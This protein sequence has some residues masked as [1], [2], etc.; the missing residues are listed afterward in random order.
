MADPRSPKS[1]RKG[2]VVNLRVSFLKDTIHVFQIPVKAV[3]QVLWDAVVSHMQL[4]ESDY[5]GLEYSNHNDDDCWLDNNKQILKQLPSPDTLLRFG[6]KF[7]TPDPGLLE[8]ELTRYCFALQ[9]RRDLQCGHLHCSENTAALLASYIVQ[10]EIGD[11]LVDEYLDTSYLNGFEFV[12][13]GQQTPEML[14]KVMDYHRQHVGEAPSE[15]DSN[16][17]DTARKVEMYGIKFHPAK[18]HE[19]VALH[20]AVAHLGVLVFQ[21]MTRINTF[22]WAKVRKLSF[23]RKKFLIKLHPE[24]YGYYKDTVEFFFD[25][26]DRCKYFWKKCIEH[27][28]FFRCQ[29][30]KKPLR[31][32][33]RVVSRGSSFRYSGRTQKELQEFVRETVVKRPQVERSTSG[34]ISSRST[35]VTPKISA[36]PSI[37]NSSDLHNSTASSGSHILESLGS[38]RLEHG[39]SADSDGGDLINQPV[40]VAAVDARLPHSDSPGADSDF[41]KFDDIPLSVSDHIILPPDVPYSNLIQSHLHHHDLDENVTDADVD[42]EF[43]ND[44]RLPSPPELLSA[45]QNGEGDSETQLKFVGEVVTPLDDGVEMTHDGVG[46]VNSQSLAEDR[47]TDGGVSTPYGHAKDAGV[48]SRAEEDGRREEAGKV[49]VSQDSQVSQRLDS[50]Q[51]PA[52]TA[53]AGAAAVEDRPDPPPPDKDSLPLQVSVSQTP[54]VIQAGE[55]QSGEPQVEVTR[56]DAG[57]VTSASSVSTGSLSSAGP[58]LAEAD[59][60]EEIPYVLYRRQY[61]EGEDQQDPGLLR[62]AETPSPQ[63]TLFR[64]SRS[65]SPRG[66]LLHED[67][68]SPEGRSG[69]TRMDRSPSAG[70]RIELVHYNK[71]PARDSFSSVDDTTSPTFDKD[72]LG[73]AHVDSP[74]TESKPVIWV[75]DGKS[76]GK[77]DSKHASPKRQPVVPEIK[78]VSSEVSPPPPPRKEGVPENPPDSA[79]DV[80]VAKSQEKEVVKIDWLDSEARDKPPAVVIG[81]DTTPKKDVQEERERTDNT[82]PSV[83]RSV[84]MKGEGK[85]AETLASPPPPPPETEK[86]ASPPPPPPE[87]EKLASPPPPPPETEKLASPPPPPPDTEKLASPP[88]PP[89]ETEKLAS[90]PPPPPE[91]EKLAS[92]PPPPPE[93]EKLASPPPPPPETEK[94]ASPP[95]PP[96]ETEKLASP[97]PPPPVPPPPPLEM[98]PKEA[99]IP[100]EPSPPLPPPPSSPPL[101]PPPPP[102]RPQNPTAEMDPNLTP[103]VQQPVLTTISTNKVTVAKPQV[104]A[105]PKPPPVMPKTTKPMS[106]KPPVA[107]KTKTIPMKPPRESGGP[108]PGREGGVPNVPPP[109]QP[110]PLPPVPPSPGVVAHPP[111]PPQPPKPLPKAPSPPRVSPPKISPPTSTTAEEQEFPPPPSEMTSSMISVSSDLDLETL[112]PPPSELLIDYS[113]QSSGTSPESPA[114]L[115]PLPPEISMTQAPT[116]TTQTP[117]EEQKGHK[118]KR[119]SS[120]SLSGKPLDGGERNGEGKVNGDRSSKQPKT[121]GGGK[122]G[123]DSGRTSSEAQRMMDLPSPAAALMFS[124]RDSPPATKPEPPAPALTFTTFRPDPSEADSIVTVTASST[125]MTGMP[126]VSV[127]DMGSNSSVST[128][129]SSLSTSPR[130][131]HKRW[132]LER[133]EEE[134]TGEGGGGGGGGG[135][136]GEQPKTAGGPPKRVS[137]HE[138]TDGAHSYHSDVSLAVMPSPVDEVSSSLG[139]SP[140]RDDVDSG[141]ILETL[142]QLRRQGS[143]SDLTYSGSSGGSDRDNGDCRGAKEVYLQYAASKCLGESSK[144]TTIDS[145]MG[146]LSSEGT[147]TTTASQHHESS[148]LDTLERIGSLEG[149][150]VSEHRKPSLDDFPPPPPFLRSGGSTSSSSSLEMAASAAVSSVRFADKRHSVDPL[151]NL[152]GRDLVEVAYTTSESESD[153]DEETET[154]RMRKMSV[155]CEGAVGGVEEAE[156]E[157]DGRKDVRR[158]SLHV[159]SGS[160]QVFTKSSPPSSSSFTGS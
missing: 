135:Q 147:M 40:D 81:T 82:Q 110:K 69:K 108:Q 29:T 36:K 156:G 83:D 99:G 57:T 94:L 18:D 106:K 112:P 26:R 38:P 111:P 144:D 25:S 154:N 19:A 113:S 122:Q 46:H 95:P 33:A 105:K 12:P 118:E 120:V 143:E 30:V 31:S 1:P 75:S 153:F 125:M 15:A 90:P 78:E 88:P 32:K 92:P 52:D 96:P 109:V 48:S 27:H 68:C 148:P 102:P 51:Q 59:L 157:G 129:A 44:D 72:F 85:E 103:P 71:L 121:Q 101:P 126:S 23:K 124:D 17:L 54:P 130:D 104:A 97:P 37:H 91:T 64:E 160:G 11:F 13:R 117:P 141:D 70:R 43:D 150:F 22:S 21:G 77:I 119:P 123:A 73:K 146:E 66:R 5:F 53:A 14:H 6:V 159:V 98:S 89:P 116:P 93:T 133:V 50:S 63:A 114:S 10:G 76:E 41:D 34:R 86:L 42:D 61:R 127:S 158:E 39:L 56:P 145:G 60:N 107:P 28:T 2:K 132:S 115:P 49:V 3:G 136:N 16:L 79:Q 100:R 155:G 35:S 131:G 55:A 149:S 128:G 65:K 58:V 139:G 67:S 140:H 84:D 7:Y 134:P 47:V 24:S 151:L 152:E 137:W 138:E 62:S 80:P 20:L 9:I 74:L 142:E 45:N 87:T 8:D 4:L